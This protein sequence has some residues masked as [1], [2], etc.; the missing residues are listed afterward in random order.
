MHQACQRRGALTWAKIAY[1]FAY[2][3]VARIN[4]D[5]FAGTARPFGRQPKSGFCG[6][7]RHRSA[8]VRTL[9]LG[10]AGH[11]DLRMPDQAGQRAADE[12]AGVPGR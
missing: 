4:P 7:Q 3:T 1:T 2:E 9:M 11:I 6:D 12:G 5:H 10:A 8:A